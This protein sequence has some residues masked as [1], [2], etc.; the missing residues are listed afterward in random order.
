MI[1]KA[2]K[3]LNRL[4]KS[5]NDL[6]SK[7]DDQTQKHERTFEKVVDLESRSMRDN[8]IFY[9]IPE[10]RDEGGIENCENLVK[11]LIRST[12]D[13]NP[14]EIQ[15]DR[16]HR[17]GSNKSRNPRP[18]VVKFHKYTD[19]ELVRSRSMIDPYKQNL[20]DRKQ[21]IGQQQPQQLREARKALMPFAKQA[22]DDGQSYQINGNKLFI[23]N[24]L[25][26]KYIDGKVVDL[27]SEGY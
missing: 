12:C 20:R 6:K 13:L 27:Q 11:D 1:E 15:F 23:N 22:R 19:R 9:G 26:K 4:G 16:A 17:L 25:K 24:S 5:C 7:L 18:T 21:G 10:S 8:L 14:A 2:E 3:E